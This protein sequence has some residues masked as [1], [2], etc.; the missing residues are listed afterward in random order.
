ME[1]RWRALAAERF[2]AAGY[3]VELPVAVEVD[4]LSR[5]VEDHVLLV[6]IVF[7]ADQKVAVRQ[8]G[9]TLDV[10]CCRVEDGELIGVRG[11]W[12]AVLQQPNLHG[13]AGEALPFE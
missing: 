8:P 12:D 9:L 7:E 3:R 6:E 2:A 1:D 11:R 5:V 13:A 10:G 4:P